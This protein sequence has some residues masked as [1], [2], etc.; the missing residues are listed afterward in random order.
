MA[1][2]GN[3]RRFTLKCLVIGITQ[4][5]CKLKNTIRT[6]RSYEIIKKVEKQPPD[7]RI[8]CINNSLYICGIK[9]D[10]CYNRLKSVLDSDTL[11]ECQSFINK[12]RE[13]SHTEIMDRQNGKFNRLLLKY[14]GGYSNNCCVYMH[15]NGIFKFKWL[16]KTTPSLTIQ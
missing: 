14:R 7:E 8:R 10:T 6:P 15:N 3:H 11:Q 9:R 12:T 1:D 2:F 5:S 4:V 16:L 13:S